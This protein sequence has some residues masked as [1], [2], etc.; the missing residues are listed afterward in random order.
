MTYTLQES[1][2]HYRE[3]VVTPSPTLTLCGYVGIQ[4]TKYDATPSGLRRIEFLGRNRFAVQN[5]GHNGSVSFWST[6]F[7]RN[8]PNA[9]V[10][11]LKAE[12]R[13]CFTRNV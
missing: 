9:G 3:A 11:R 2:P 12:L 4:D 6:A 8:T 5:S 7:R 13:S 10:S 1:L